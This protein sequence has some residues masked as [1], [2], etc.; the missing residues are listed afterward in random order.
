[1]STDERLLDGFLSDEPD[2]PL[3]DRNSIALKVANLLI[4]Y[5]ALEHWRRMVQDARTEI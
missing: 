2:K 1:M 5:D 4:K 3:L